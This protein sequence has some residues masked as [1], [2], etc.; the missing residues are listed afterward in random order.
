MSTTSNKIGALGL[1]LDSRTRVSNNSA[2]HCK[3]GSSARASHEMIDIEPL[4]RGHIAG[5][6]QSSIARMAYDPEL[7]SISYQSLRCV[8]GVQATG[9]HLGS[10]V[11]AIR[12]P[13]VAGDSRG[14]WTARH[15]A[16]QA[17]LVHVLRILGY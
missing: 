6:Q 11:G 7:R 4:G 15:D 2:A 1:G 14:L 12:V 8:K 10:Q 17:M 13:N 5:S 16:F 9:I 3:I